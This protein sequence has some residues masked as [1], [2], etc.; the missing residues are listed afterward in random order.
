MK[1]RTFAAKEVILSE[2]DFSSEMYFI[3]KGE[4]RVSKGDTFLAKLGE[5]SYFGEM[6]AVAKGPRTASVRAIVPVH[7]FVLEANEVQEM[8]AASPEA[9][10]LVVGGATSRLEELLRTQ[11]QQEETAEGAP[12][13]G[14]PGSGSA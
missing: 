12:A 6:G 5:G 4:V 3:L 11:E 2:G 14:S 8:M 1:Y 9:G 10:Q 7:A 13:E